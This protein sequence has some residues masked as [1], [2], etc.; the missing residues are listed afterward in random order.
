VATVNDAAVLRNV[1]VARPDS[2]L[3]ETRN[4]VLSRHGGPSNTYTVDLTGHAVLPA[5]VNA[6]DHL[7]LNGIPP[8]P[9]HPSFGNSYAWSAAFEPHFDDGGVKQAMAVPSD[10]RHWQG[11]LKNA[12]CG[13]TTVM[14]HD[15]AQ[16]VFDLPGY[17]ARVVRRYGW[18]HSLHWQYGPPVAQSYQCT[19]E[20]VG[21][22]IH[23]AE[24]TDAAAAN[25]LQELQILDC[26]QANTVL[27][28]GVAFNDADVARVIAS[29][30]AMVWCPSSNLSVL[31]KTVAPPRLRRLYST[32][33]L[34]LGTDSRLSGARDLLH[35]LRVAADH[36]DFGARELLQLV[37]TSSRRVLRAEPAR[38]DIVVFR[39]R[40]ADPFRDFL[41]LGRH[42]LRAVVRSGEPLIT[43]PDFE[44]WFVQRSVR[45]TQVL[46]DGH[47]K[48]CASAMLS[49][50]GSQYSGLEPGLML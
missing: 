16:P 2:G 32:G 44:D 13:A 5:L 43:D 23:L 19:P 40:S 11:G 29:G 38:D 14:H 3:I 20:D 35:E 42:E 25:E 27:I 28:H 18:A 9:P 4:F 45:Y 12:L 7:H 17:P 33:R 22:F 34:A 1:L 39:N 47:P 41:Q 26:L 48:L 6:H 24:G 37:T 10:L 50:D 49:P 46:L 30:A 21:W 36:S 15:P 8:L 31:G